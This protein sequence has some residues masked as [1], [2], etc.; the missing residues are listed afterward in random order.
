MTKTIITLIILCALT[1]TAWGQDIP[2]AT[3]DARLPDI[4]TLDTIT[5]ISD[6][7]IDS[8]MGTD[9]LFWDDEPWCIGYE[10][11]QF[12]IRCRE[13]PGGMVKIEIPCDCCTGDAIYWNCPGSKTKRFYEIVQKCD[14]TEVK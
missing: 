14:T 13:V 7:V 3:W 9:T 11:I 5:Y 2:T 4:E 6:T 12:R 10:T 8:I 1:V